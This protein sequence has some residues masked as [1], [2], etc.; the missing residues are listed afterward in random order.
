MGVSHE[1]GYPRSARRKPVVATSLI[2]PDRMTSD[3]IDRAVRA[4][5]KSG[6][7]LYRIDRALLRKL[8]P[9]VLLTQDLCDV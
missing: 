3:E 5:N 8:A 2:D 4:A 1:C 6:R 7:S 9:D